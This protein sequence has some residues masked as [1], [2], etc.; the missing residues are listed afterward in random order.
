[1]TD[2]P[3]PEGTAG[4]SPTEQSDQ[5]PALNIALHQRLLVEGG[6]K[7]STCASARAALELIRLA[8]EADARKTRQ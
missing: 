1:M 5:L 8:K 4:R 3:I 2:E 6:A 7:P